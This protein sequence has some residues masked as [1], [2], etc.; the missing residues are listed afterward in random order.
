MGIESYFLAPG[1][2]TALFPEGMSPSNV[3]DG[4]RSV[5]ADMREWYSDPVWIQYGKGDG[6]YT[7]AFASATS[8]TIAA[9]DVTAIYHAS[10]RVKISG[11][12]TGTRYAT[13]AS[14]SY[15]DPNTTVVVT[16]DSGTLQS[17]ALTVWLSVI[18]A[19]NSPMPGNIGVLGSAA[20]EDIGTSGAVVPLLNGANSWT[21]TQTFQAFRQSWEGVT[22]SWNQNDSGHLRLQHVVDATFTTLFTAQVDTTPNRVTF[23][24]E[25]RANGGFFIADVEVE[26]FASEADA[27]AGSSTS[28]IMSPLRVQNAIAHYPV[29]IGNRAERTTLESTD[30]LHIGVPAGELM[31]KAT[32]ATLKTLMSAPDFTVTGLSL[33]SMPA[34]STHGLSAEPRRVEAVVRID[35]THNGHVAGDAYDVMTHDT[36]ASGLTATVGRNASDVWV[37]LP[38]SL[39]FRRRDTNAVASITYASCSIEIRAWL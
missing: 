34:F 31:R 32:L 8:F 9:A 35:T 17:E 1:A 37:G 21:A 29:A 23:A 7:A 2:N 11:P 4:M 3:N 39:A 18:P 28:L 27:D 15:T 26:G 12:L 5:Q 24:A 25:L 14:S 20:S 16:L 30:M 13:I 36:D 6:P 19:V 33:A 22:F 10:R 38:S